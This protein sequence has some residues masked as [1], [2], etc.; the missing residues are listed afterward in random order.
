M[1]DEKNI[2]QKGWMHASKG[3][4]GIPFDASS[5]I[6]LYFLILMKNIP[7]KGCFL[8]KN[9]RQKGCS[10]QKGCFIRPIF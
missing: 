2:P 7:Q 6:T 4:S 8:E 1:F 9:M 10:H 3:K 5:Y